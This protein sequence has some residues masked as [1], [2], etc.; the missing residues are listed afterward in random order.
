MRGSGGGT[1]RRVA[2]G[3]TRSRA[4]ALK[5]QG[6]PCVPLASNAPARSN[7]SNSPITINPC[8]LGSMNLPTM[9]PPNVANPR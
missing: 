1:E 6:T 4:K 8:G 2:H 3:T 9:A 7:F 5:R